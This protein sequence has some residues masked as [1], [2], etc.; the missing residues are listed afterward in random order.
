MRT[1]QLSAARIDEILALVDELK[2]SGENAEVF[3]QRKGIRYGQIRGWLSH[4]P[5]CRTVSVPPT[6][7]DT[8]SEGQV[9]SAGG[10]VFAQLWGSNS[11]RRLLGQVGSFVSTSLR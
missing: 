5:R 1:D 11:P 9:L 8:R 10:L 2:A 7:L 3:A 6:P 4:A